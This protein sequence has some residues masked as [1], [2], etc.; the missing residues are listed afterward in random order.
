MT[1]PLRVQGNFMVEDSKSK[2]SQIFSE[3]FKS[4]ISTHV[5]RNLSRGLASN[6]AS[7]AAKP[8]CYDVD[9]TCRLQVFVNYAGFSDA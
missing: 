8:S 6:R 3:F 5:V 1:F 9:D 7:K 2:S 4:W